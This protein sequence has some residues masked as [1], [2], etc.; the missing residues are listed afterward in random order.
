MDEELLAIALGD[1]GNGVS[2]RVETQSANGVETTAIEHKMGIRASATCSLNFVDATGYLI[3]EENRGLAAMFKMM[4]IERITVGLQGLGLAHG[5]HVA[6]LALNSFRYSEVYLGVPQAG[7][8]LAPINTRLSP[9]ETS[10]ILNDGEIQ[11]LII[12]QA[13]LPLYQEIRAELRSE[14]RRVG[15]EC[16]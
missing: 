16:V 5:S 12:G 2:L 14:E 15:K 13:F 9:R 3:G 6:I 11:T 7:L 1:I 8:V 10:F 4:N